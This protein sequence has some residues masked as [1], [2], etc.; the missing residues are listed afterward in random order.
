M[1]FFDYKDSIRKIDVVVFG[2]QTNTG[3]VSG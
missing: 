3:H 2:A 1:T